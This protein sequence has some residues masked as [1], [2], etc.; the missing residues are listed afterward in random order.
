MQVI[1][2][3]PAKHPDLTAY[4]QEMEKILNEYFSYFPPPGDPTVLT[5]LAK[6]VY[7]NDYRLRGSKWAALNLPVTKLQ[8]L[9]RQLGFIRIEMAKKQGYDS[10]LDMILSRNSIPKSVYNNF[11][12]HV[13]TVIGKINQSLVHTRLPDWFY[14]TYNLP[15]LACLLPDFPW[16]DIADVLSQSEKFGLTPQITNSI[17]IKE[18]AERSYLHYLPKTKRFIIYLNGHVNIRHQLLDLI[19]ELSHVRLYLEK[20]EPT[21]K[22]MPGYLR[23]SEAL[24]INLELLRQG[25][26]SLADAVQVNNLIALRGTLF[27]I[28]FYHQPGQGLSRLYAATFNR[29]F[30]KAS[31]EFNPLYLIDENLLLR[32]FSNLIH[33][34]ALVHT[35]SLDS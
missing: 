27:E 7:S 25:T 3:H 13:D 23:E 29:C 17:E 26:P 18:Y 8:S 22:D 24:N 20:G 2:K 21:T 31:Q 6:Q 5:A 4:Y 10:Y 28:N 35:T 33:S 15:C 34:L 14:E 19:H 30:L 12:L 16:K 1:N 9:Y 32:P 11:I